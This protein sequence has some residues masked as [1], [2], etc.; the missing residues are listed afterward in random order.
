MQEIER[1]TLELRFSNHLAI[2]ASDLAAVLLALSEDYAKLT[3]GRALVVAN[4]RKGSIILAIKDAVVAAA[5]VAVPVKEI[6]EGIASIIKLARVVSDALVKEKNA[7]DDE[8]PKRRRRQIG[9]KTADRL[10]QTA[11]S[12]GGDVSLKYTE[13]TDGSAIDIKVTHSDAERWDQRRIIEEVLRSGVRSSQSA[14]ELPYNRTLSVPPPPPQLTHSSWL[15]DML[16]ASNSDE[17]LKLAKSLHSLRMT[18]LAGTIQN[19]FLRLGRGDLAA[20]F[21]REIES[22]TKL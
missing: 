2:P 13:D 10:F 3:K 20:V 18:H 11:L 14:A 19:E 17:A 1:G 15:P 12:S 4:M 5:T 9:T 6:A 22:L 16:A 21:M 8:L 7:A